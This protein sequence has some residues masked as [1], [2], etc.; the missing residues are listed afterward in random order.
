MK[1]L[2]IR[3]SWRWINPT[4]KLLRMQLI[5]KLIFMCSAMEKCSGFNNSYQLKC[6]FLCLFNEWCTYSSLLGMQGQSQISFQSLFI[7]CII[8]LYRRFQYTTVEFCCC[9][10]DYYYRHS[11]LIVVGTSSPLF[12]LQPVAMRCNII[13]IN[14]FNTAFIY[15]CKNEWQKEKR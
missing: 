12:R 8:H 15:R 9:N 11:R 4:N 13:C 7:S 14:L 6:N 1:S 3:L 10:D 5:Q 2:S